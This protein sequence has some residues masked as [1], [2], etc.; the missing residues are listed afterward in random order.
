MALPAIELRNVSISFEGELILKN[1]SLQVQAGET[2]VLIGPSGHG[3]S[4]IIKVMAGLVKPD[5][6][7]I[8]IYGIKLSETPGARRQQTISKMSMLFQKNALFDSMSN[9]ENIAFPLREVT[10]LSEAEIQI[11]VDK[12][13]DDVGLRE[14]KDLMPDE[15]SGGMQK[16]LG[17]ARA[18]AL[19]PE[20]V[21][22]DEPTAGLDPITSR[23]II[24]LIMRLKEQDKATIVV[25][26]S[27][28]N[29]A[30]QLSKKVIMVYRQGLVFTGEKAFSQFVQGL[31]A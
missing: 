3:K 9:G 10:D 19:K 15:I 21:F 6:G 30:H 31:S 28:M 29:R 22:Y 20:I 14:A 2:L 11:I 12:Y 4:A 24:D 1:I 5:F 25:V 17:I 16:R 13:L 26:T 8:L 23:K 18:L 7:D 27:D